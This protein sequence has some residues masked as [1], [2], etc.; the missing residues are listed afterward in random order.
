MTITALSVQRFI[1]VRSPFVSHQ[2]KRMKKS[3]RRKLLPIIWLVSLVAMAP[4]AVVRRLKAVDY[5]VPDDHTYF[6]IEDW[7][8]SQ[9][10]IGY[11]VFL[12][13]FIYLLPGSLL[14]TL[15]LTITVKLT[16]AKAN[17]IDHA[18][19]ASLTNENVLVARRKAGFQCMLFAVFF[20][21]CWLPYHVINLM[22]DLLNTTQ[23]YEFLL[24][25]L[26]VALLVAHANSAINPLLYCFAGKR[27]RGGAMKSFRMEPIVG[28]RLRHNRS[29]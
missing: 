28:H 7:S 18:L 29:P 16:A 3:H 8:T 11:S 5:P 10:R 12:L 25:A 27:F 23:N 22:I 20:V 6:C 21:V 4:L 2:L 19:D 17:T 15:Y 13:C 14:L 9:Q 24:D 26:S 1:A